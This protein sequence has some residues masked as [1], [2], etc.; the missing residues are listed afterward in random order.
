M[1]HTHITEVNEI[2]SCTILD[3]DVSYG[4]LAFYTNSTDEYVSSYQETKFAI[5]CSFFLS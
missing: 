5:S 1:S 3:S 2:I 4:A